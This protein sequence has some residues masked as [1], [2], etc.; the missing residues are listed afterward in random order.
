M[1]VVKQEQL[2]PR[3]R[4]AQAHAAGKTWIA[5]GDYAPGAAFSELPVEEGEQWSERFESETNYL[6][7][8]HDAPPKSYGAHIVAQ[9][10]AL[11]SPNSDLEFLSK[12]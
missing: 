6:E 5:R 11:F 3:I 12:A 4:V 10:D 7:R 1:R 2:V 9:S 8:A